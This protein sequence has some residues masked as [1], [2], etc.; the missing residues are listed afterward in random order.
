MSEFVSLFPEQQNFHQENIT[1]G[2]TKDLCVDKQESGIKNICYS[3]SHEYIVNAALESHDNTNAEKLQEV[4]CPTSCS[5][6]G[7]L[8][9]PI[10]FQGF[11]QPNIEN[12]QGHRTAPSLQALYS[13]AQPFS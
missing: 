13:A 4:S 7:Q 8:R 12:F 11:V 1:S 3:Y 9:D 10:I 6:L 2:Q 5:E